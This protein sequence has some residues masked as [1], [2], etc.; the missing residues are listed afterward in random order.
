VEHRQA[1]Q[2]LA[3]TV[4]LASS[5]TTVSGYPHQVAVARLVAA[6]L[7][8][9]ALAETLVRGVAAV[10]QAAVSQDKLSVLSDVA[11]LPIASLLSGKQ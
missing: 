11:A 8:A 3:V 9:Q 10:A 4:T 5:I 6:Q 2:A 1:L 7:A